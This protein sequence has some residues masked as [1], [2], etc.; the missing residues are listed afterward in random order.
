MG[1]FM[2]LYKFHMLISVALAMTV[3]SRVVRPVFSGKQTLKHGDMHHAGCRPF[4]H[5]RYTDGG[6]HD[7]KQHQEG[8]LDMEDYWISHCHSCRSF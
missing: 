8:C 1:D 7:A 4:R 5:Q 3:F 6:K 2:N